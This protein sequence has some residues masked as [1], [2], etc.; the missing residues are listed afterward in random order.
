M[1][2]ES[3]IDDV[4]GPLMDEFLARKRKGE[5][6]SLSEFVRRHPELESEIRQ[7]FP[8]VAM[9][10]SVE[11]STDRTDAVT[12]DG[13]E[14]ERL[15]DYRIIREI[16]RGGMG[17]VYEAI[18]ESLGR[19][20]AIKVLPWQNVSDKRQVKRFQREA[21]ISAALH[22]TNIVPV[23]G[24]GEVDGVH[25][26]AMQ[27]IRGQSLDSVLVE[28]RNLMESRD[29][30]S[31]NGLT[32][33]TGTNDGRSLAE[34]LILTASAQRQ[35][36]TKLPEES[37]A[38]SD[39]STPQSDPSES[40]RSMS[41]T[42]FRL[43][44]FRRAAELMASAA[45]AVD[46]A[47][48]Q[49]VLHRDIKP[50]NLMIDT[51]GAIWVADFGLAKAGDS[52]AGSASSEGDLQDDLTNTGDLIGTIRY[53]APERFQGVNDVRSDIY[54]LGL[55]LYE[56]L[57]LK[58]AFTAT[59]RLSLIQLITSAS[60]PL[61]RQ[62]VPT[63]PRD[64]ETIIVKATQTDPELR[65]SNAGELA[66]DL[67]CFLA[68]KPI[69][70]R[71][72]PAL[73]RFV[74]WCRRRPA[75]AALSALVLSLL[76]VLAVG[77]TVAAVSLNRSL[78]NVKI[79]KDA[80]LAANLKAKRSLFDAYVAQATAEIAGTRPGR[81]FKSMN[82][83]RKASRLLNEVKESPEDVLQ[84]RN[85]ALHAMTLDDL[86]IVE[87]RSVP[88][89]LTAHHKFGFDRDVASV[90][91]VHPDGHVI[92]ESVEGGK[93]QSQFPGD[94]KSNPVAY[95]RISSDGR[96]I[97]VHGETNAGIQ[98]LS[99]WDAQLEEFVLEEVSTK[100]RSYA[101]SVE[102]SDDGR[103]FAYMIA[104]L[105]IV[106]DLRTRNEIC[107][108]QTSSASDF[109]DFCPD[110]DHILLAASDQSIGI[111]DV[112]STGPA[113]ILQ[114]NSR[115]TDADFSPDGRYVAST[116]YDSNVYVWDLQYPTRP[117]QTLRG[118]TSIARSAEFNPN[119]NLLVSTAW[120]STS[121]IW[122]PQV[123][124]ELLRSSERAGTFSSQGDSLAF[125][126]GTSIG[127]WSVAD[128]QYCH[129]IIESDRNSDIDDIDF[130]PDGTMLVLANDSGLYVYTW[131][132]R[133]LVKHLN[134]FGLYMKC[135]FSS[136]GKFIYASGSG[137]VV[138]VNVS[139][140]FTH[141][142]AIESRYVNEAQ[143]G[144]E[145]DM[146][147]DA[148]SNRIICTVSYN[149]FQ[150]LDMEDLKPLGE[151]HESFP[152]QWLVA[153]SPKSRFI[154]LTGKHTDQLSV[155][156]GDSLEPVFQHQSRVR[157]GMWTGFSSDGKILAIASSGE[158]VF[159]STVTWKTIHEIQNESTTL[160]RVAFSPDGTMVA[161][162]SRYKVKLL[163]L[164]SFDL[165]G[166][167]VP[168][169]GESLCTSEPEMAT[170]VTFSRD[171]RWLATGTWKNSIHAWD[172]AKIHAELQSMDVAWKSR[173][174]WP[175]TKTDCNVDSNLVA[176]NAHK[177]GSCRF[178]MPLSA[179]AKQAQ[180][181]EKLNSAVQ[182]DPSSATALRSRAKFHSDNE[183][184]E[185]SIADWS[186]LIAMQPNDVMLRYLRAY[187]CSHADDVW[188]KQAIADY[189]FVL[190]AD[191]V[192]N[193]KYELS[194]NSLA[195]LLVTGPIELRDADRARIL[196][197]KANSRSPGTDY[198]QNTLAWALYRCGEYR[199]SRELLLDN[200]SRESNNQ[201]GLDWL[202]LAMCSHQLNMAEESNN[203]WN[204][205]IRYI[206]TAEE[207][208]LEEL[209]KLS[210]EV[211][212]AI[213]P[214]EPEA[215]AT[216][217]IPAQRGSG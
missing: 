188:A 138:K 49:G 84:L 57:V 213:G 148:A 153:V 165:L 3:D 149:Q 204:Q 51:E 173:S 44:Y 7:L 175:T 137:G 162:Q 67:R 45:E 9:M 142:R 4:L 14:L 17:V 62:A 94:W 126:N 37:V 168:K 26:L 82:A 128:D 178:E 203:A 161:I 21:R 172:L 90:A 61:A 35:S 125:E 181:L 182:S 214:I 122:Q 201:K 31:P 147:I 134:P 75:V 56:I 157:S 34:S 65:Y 109:L 158:I 211:A 111:I 112:Q 1:T 92:V 104:E 23:Y 85:A 130:H 136:D 179:K 38:A 169:Y 106:M 117:L 43:N 141:G 200:V 76:V 36:G 64:L 150:L 63:I 135:R 19:H 177:P 186:S 80:E 53:L 114:H 70:A 27:F 77:S 116:C 103:L 167:F 212:I 73:E 86:Q 129:S 100:K 40:S 24:V 72:T 13:S 140:L 69:V 120:D 96:F 183:D 208:E 207:S 123:G 144:M 174:V 71:R 22:H 176:G 83:I 15:G 48:S 32:R 192:P 5:V 79:A 50:A 121:R 164:E 132:E 146:A 206:A 74:L 195:W 101:R 139:K 8:A 199:E 88:S 87:R 154:A 196:A 81:R 39:S 110:G 163:D 91:R 152:E 166:E 68:G 78:T 52:L 98:S 187:D 97:A 6:P 89:T 108:H 210:R 54:S 198:I 131:P 42:A 155:L 93:L 29:G 180:T 124:Q 58:P 191:D 99:V 209:Q 171:S 194:L 95:T 215:E 66:F 145:V 143:Q 193:D 205:S 10:E 2:S 185:R 133:K 113:C 160:G 41:D 115:V 119:G 202:C 197:R 189:D 55:T 30:A 33:A 184:Y 151:I 25:F 12:R 60:P 16:G 216:K 156:D 11:A 18:Q 46:Y 105:L 127:R 107:R 190:A 217:K 159:V 170:G 28:L 118:H 59:D 47:H 102:F 20:V